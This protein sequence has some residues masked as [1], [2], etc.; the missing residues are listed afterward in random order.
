MKL[1]QKLGVAT[2]EELLR[3]I[4][5]DYV[6]L[7]Q[8][9][10]IGESILEEKQAVRAV[11]GRKEPERMLRKGLTAQ[12][13][14]GVDGEDTLTLTFF[15][16]KYTVAGLEEGKEYLFYGLVEGTLTRREMTNPAI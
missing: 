13:L 11:L 6:D 3:H 16:G 7:R 1:Y 15:N 10:S 12:R 8:A 9:V 5:R 4:P 14:L 2:V